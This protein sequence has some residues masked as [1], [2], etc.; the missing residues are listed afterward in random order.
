MENEKLSPIELG[1]LIKFKKDARKKVE[2]GIASLEEE[3]AQLQTEKSNEQVDA[4]K[5]EIYRYFKVGAAAIANRE[6][7]VFEYLEE[8]EARK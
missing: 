1:E 3:K 7:M 5:K 2:S 6:G 8:P 4:V